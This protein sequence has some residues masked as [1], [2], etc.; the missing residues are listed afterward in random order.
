LV[1]PELKLSASE[2][3]TT[4]KRLRRKPDDRS[5]WAL[6]VGSDTPRRLTEDVAVSEQ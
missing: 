1:C 3:T 5:V 4:T 2:A 6:P